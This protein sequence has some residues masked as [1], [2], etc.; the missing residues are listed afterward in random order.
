[1]III[2]FPQNLYNSKK[3]GIFAVET[4]KQRNIMKT[5]TMQVEKSGDNIISALF[6]SAI[7][8]LVLGAYVL[9]KVFIC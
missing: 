2:F 7:V 5:K 6:I 4:L 3:S 9:A 8:L 1:M